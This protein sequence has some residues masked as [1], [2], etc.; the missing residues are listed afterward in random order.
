MLQS[1]NTHLQQGSDVPLQGSGWQCGA[2][3]LL[4]IAWVG[5]GPLDLAR[6]DVTQPVVDETALVL[7]TVPPGWKDHWGQARS[8]RFGKHFC[9]LAAL[10]RPFNN[11]I[12]LLKG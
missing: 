8:E 12:V 7:W 2:S 5:H 4:R 1:H 6:P 10:F 11:E 9:R 3:A